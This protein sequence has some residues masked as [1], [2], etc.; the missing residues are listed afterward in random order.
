MAVSYT[1]NLYSA[2]NLLNGA[3]DQVFSFSDTD[4]AAR[5]GTFTSGGE[6]AQRV[7][8]VDD[9]NTTAPNQ[10]NDAIDDF[11]DGTGARQV[12]GEDVTVTFELNG[13]V[14]TRTFPAGSQVQAEFQQ[15]F[16]N[17]PTIVAIRIANPLAGQPGEPNL[18]TAAYAVVGGAIPPGTTFGTTSGG[19]NAGDIAYADIPC[20]V[21][22]T[23]LDTPSG[24]R[25]VE[26]LRPGD[27]VLTADDGPQEITWVGE[28]VVSRD[29]LL[30]RPDWRPIRLPG[31][32]ALSPLHRV[33]R[34]GPALS[35][36]TGL[37]EALVEARFLGR[38]ITPK[39]GIR[40]IH[41][42]CARHQI[43]RADGQWVETLLRGDAG[44]PLLD[45]AAQRRHPARPL[46][47]GYEAGLIAADLHA[48]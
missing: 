3:G 13:S 6:T 4:T 47:A 33:L 19:Q 14:V 37:A 28:R 21:P 20:F 1:I 32:L 40:Y 22:G 9:F 26:A 17:G 2:Q 18:I 16:S 29:E 27:H 46:L 5:S 11:D 48:A 12:L 25:L 10:A 45:E 36:L 8:I 15:D 30:R 24:S 39:T 35:L 34:S 42:T 7:T 38:S 31:G 41:F 44:C 43:V 23:R